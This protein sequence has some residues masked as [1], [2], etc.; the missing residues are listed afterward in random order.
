MDPHAKDS[1]HTEM[2]ERGIRKD[3]AVRGQK[4]L[5]HKR[6]GDREV[7][8]KTQRKRSKRGTVDERK[9]ISSGPKWN[10]GRLGNAICVIRTCKQ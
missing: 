2:N 4:T 5:Y 10:K 1:C 8:Q 6:E 7:R 3:C 9:G